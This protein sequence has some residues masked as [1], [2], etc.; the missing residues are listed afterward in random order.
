[1]EILVARMDGAPDRHG[2]SFALG[3]I[4]LTTG[5]LV[6]RDF[7][8]SQSPIGVATLRADGANV[9]ADVHLAPGLARRFLNG[10]YPAIGGQVVESVAGRRGTIV[11][12]FAVREVSLCD[13]ENAD[14]RI[15]RVWL[16]VTARGV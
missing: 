6:T 10:A 14:P 15:G 13:Q 7:D 16:A 3:S 9:Y 1:M 4:K 5:V 8:R 12:R 2:I 11:S